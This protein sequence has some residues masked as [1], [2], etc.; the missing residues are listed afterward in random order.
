MVINNSINDKVFNILNVVFM[1]VILAIIIYP[2]YFVLIASI[3]DP[4]A[5]NTGQVFI[6]PKGFSLK[7]YEVVF[8]NDQVWVGYK[9]SIFLAVVGTFY[10]V[11]LTLPCS[12]ALSRK[13]MVGR[14]VIAFIFAFTMYFSGGL[15]PS[16]LLVRSLG[17]YNSLWALIIPG[18]AGVFLIIMTRTYLKTNIP[19]ELYD[20]ANIDGCSDFRVFF[21]IILPLSLP[22]IAVISLFYA[23]GHW[24]QFFA[25]LIYIE[26]EKRY[27]LQLVLRMI[28]LQTQVAEEAISLEQ[29]ESEA[30]RVSVVESLKYALII[31]ASVPVLAAY[32]F[33]QKYFVKGL[34]IGSVKG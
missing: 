34:T 17:L 19:E 21:S 33:A 16:Y 28:L 23:I 3:S 9:N 15:I 24:N 30:Q 31:V 27:P 13:V 32:P 22:I 10:N 14:N 29:V 18:G 20:S 11:A 4:T 1:S 2:M 6:Y 25:A 5:V 7:G 8:K 26:S 12:Y